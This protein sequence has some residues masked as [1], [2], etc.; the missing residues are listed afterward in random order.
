MVLSLWSCVLLRRDPL[1]VT[2]VVLVQLLIHEVFNSTG[3]SCLWNFT[4][5]IDDGVLFK[6]IVFL[7]NI[8]HIPDPPATTIA[9]I[10]SWGI[11]S[12]V[13]NIYI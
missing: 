1:L 6:F 10:G 12:C 11:G 5:G 9:H 8:Q 7:K 3:F 2:L 13:K 4:A